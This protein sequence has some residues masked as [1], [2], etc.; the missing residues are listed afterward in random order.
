MFGAAAQTT[1]NSSPTAVVD[2]RVTANPSRP[3]PAGPTRPASTGVGGGQERCP[4]SRSVAWCGHLPGYHPRMAPGVPQ[5][6]PAGFPLVTGP[7]DAAAIRNPTPGTGEAPGHRAAD[8]P[9]GADVPA[10]PS[11]LDAAGALLRA[12]ASP[13]RMRLVLSL[14]RGPRCV[15]ELVDELSLPQ[16]LVSQHLRVLRISRLV[17][18]ERAGREIVYSLVDAHVAHVVA[19]AVAHARETPS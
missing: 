2:R 1:P 14:A 16:P 12:L 11:A 6:D 13:V 19:D 15:H 8:D 10:E 9:S 7:P 18:A 17:R 3:V 5:P 4:P